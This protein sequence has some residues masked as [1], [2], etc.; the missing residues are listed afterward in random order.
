M[1]SGLGPATDAGRAALSVA[2]WLGV[3]FVMLFALNTIGGWVRLSG[4]GVAIPQ[5]PIINGSLLPPLT[6]AGWDAVKAGYD[7]DQE[8]LAQRVRR[9][10]LAPGNLGRQAG[11]LAEFKGMFLTEWS[12]RLLA[13]LVGVLGAGC[14]TVALR[15]AD[16]R[17][18]IGGP[19]AVAGIFIIAQAALGGLLVQ[20]GTNTHWLFLH[21]ANAGI[22]LAC[23]LVA[24]LRLLD[25][26]RA[27]RP[28]PTALAVLVHA[29]LALAWLQLVCGALVAGS[30]ANEPTVISQAWKMSPAFLWEGFKPLSWNLLDNAALH[31]W[32][33]H[34]MATLLVVT[35]VALYV[36]AWRGAEVPERL[37]LALRISA[38][39][40]AVQVVLGI[41][42][43]YSGFTPLVSLAHQF[44]GMCLLMSLVLAAFDVRRG[45]GARLVIV[46]PQPVVAAGSA[47]G[48]P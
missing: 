6:A 37:R 4:A 19:M 48:R 27:A 14:V 16:L 13:A 8:R 9:G 28:R 10:E 40:V 18:R 7:A 21:Q 32:I 30:R 22:V 24:I 25:G 42:N 31:Q 41:G 20:S 36:V 26:E 38:T 17:R 44:M 39:F 33:H 43:V 45:A 23:V 12:H 34:W 46:A 11:D 15:R 2:P 47:G 3:L 1:A 35:L 5:W 29:A